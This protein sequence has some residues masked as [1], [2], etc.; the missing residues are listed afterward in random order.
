VR[1][2]EEKA[3]EQINKDVTHTLNAA[4]RTS[5]LKTLKNDSGLSPPMGKNS[6][7]RRRVF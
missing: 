3:I 1:A 6:Y 5:S 7:R 2:K 4:W